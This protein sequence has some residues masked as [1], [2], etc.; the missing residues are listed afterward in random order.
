MMD[1]VKKCSDIFRFSAKKQALFDS[2]VNKLVP[3]EMRNKI[4]DVCRTR[5]FLRIDGLERTQEMY[6]P[7]LS[8]LEEIKDNAAGTYNREACADAIGVYCTM[9]SFNFIVALIITRSILAYT[10]PLTLELQKKKI[11]TV[12]LSS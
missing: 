6:E 10:L 4:P 5:W 7:L 3:T 2:F 8:T 1:T 12:H 9:P 11:K